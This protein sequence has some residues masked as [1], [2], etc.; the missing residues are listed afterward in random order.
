MYFPLKVVFIVCKNTGN[1]MHVKTISDYAIRR[2]MQNE[3]GV[4]HHNVCRMK[5]IHFNLYQPNW[6]WSPAEL[7][8]SFP[9]KIRW[10]NKNC[11]SMD[12]HCFDSAPTPN[13]QPFPPTLRHPSICTSCWLCCVTSAK[14][15]ILMLTWRMFF[16]LISGYY[17]HITT[18]QFWCKWK[19]HLFLHDQIQRIIRSY[20]LIQLPWTLPRHVTAC[21]SWICLWCAVPFWFTSLPATNETQ[22]EQSER[23]QIVDQVVDDGAKIGDGKKRT[24]LHRQRKSA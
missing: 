13:P 14:N 7:I 19:A 10:I 4:T 18:F 1:H 2:L 17:V 5:S 20:W 16:P 12:S 3:L 23:E 22:S 6:R 15:F 21:V 9:K 8:P 11:V 24:L